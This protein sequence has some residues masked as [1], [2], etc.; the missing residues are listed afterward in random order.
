MIDK[1]KENIVQI[2]KRLIKL[3]SGKDIPEIYESKVFSKDSS[4]IVF[5]DIPIKFAAKKILLFITV[6]RLILSLNPQF[7]SP[8]LIQ[9]IS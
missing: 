3:D 6:L 8:L 1:K 7:I 5:F 4:M 9:K 2:A